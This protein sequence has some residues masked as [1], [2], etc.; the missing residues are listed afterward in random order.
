MREVYVY[1]ISSLSY[2]TPTNLPLQQP[3]PRS[4]NGPSFTTQPQYQQYHT[5]HHSQNYFA[6]SHRTPKGLPPPPELAQRVEEAKTSAKLLLQCVQS[7]PPSEIPHNDLIR[8]FVD[9]C[10]SASRSI[11]GYINSENPPPDEDTLLTL[12]ETNDLL[13]TAMSRHQR[14]ILQSRKSTPGIS[15]NPSPNPPPPTHQHGP[16]EAPASAPAPTHISAPTGPP[17]GMSFTAPLGPPPARRQQ[18]P[19]PPPVQTNTAADDR[20]PFGDHNA[21]EED[22]MPPPLSPSYGLPPSSVSNG[23][24]GP[25]KSAND[26]GGVY[27]P[28]YAQENGYGAGKSVDDEGGVYRP[29]YAQ[30]SY[31]PQKNANDEGGVYRPGYER[32][33]SSGYGGSGKQREGQGMSNGAG[34]GT[35]RGVGDEEEEGRRPVQYRF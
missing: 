12:I 8:E 15:P 23:A 33:E 35:R 25:Q 34:T 32:G 19:Q 26:E 28:G 18:P 21:H 31:G 2:S 14:A 1:P 30:E 11:Q 24:Y 22:R 29:G 27:R 17:P 4:L 7:T 16:F 13:A 3:M 20:D 10:Q 5:S 6:H 9:R